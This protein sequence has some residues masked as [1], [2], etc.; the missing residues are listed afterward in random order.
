VDGII[1]E[2]NVSG[3]VWLVEAIG[4][5]LK[6]NS[7]GNVIRRAI[8]DVCLRPIRDPGEDA[9]DE[10]LSWLDVPQKNKQVIK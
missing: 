10:T 4:S 8:N 3:P 9:K 1:W 6:W 2:Q 7:A 5:P